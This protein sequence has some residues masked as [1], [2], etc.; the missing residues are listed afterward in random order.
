MIIDIAQAV[1]FI[2]EPSKFAF[3]LYTLDMLLLF[4]KHKV[5]CYAMT[6]HATVVTNGSWPLHSTRLLRRSRNDFLGCND[7][8]EKFIVPWVR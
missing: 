3:T 4:V 1:K 5:S 7:S 6:G 8:N 2:S